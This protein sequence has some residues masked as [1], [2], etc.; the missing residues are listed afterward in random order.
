MAINFYLYFN[1][2]ITSID[3]CAASSCWWWP[4]TISDLVH[5]SALT[6]DPLNLKV[7]YCFIVAT[8]WITHP[9]RAHVCFSFWGFC[10]FGLLQHQPTRRKARQFLLKRGILVNCIEVT[11]VNFFLFGLILFQDHHVA[12][13]PLAIGCGFILADA[14]CR[15]FV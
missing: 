6:M 2:R 11:I 9:L 14:F 13:D 3:P 7:N 8:R 4:S 1:E 12:S 10:L 15:S 5:Y